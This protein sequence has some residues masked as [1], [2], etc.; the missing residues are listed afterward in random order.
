MSRLRSTKSLDRPVA[1][2]LPKK[3]I[4]IYCEGELTEP[5]YFTAMKQA[6]KN[7]MVEIVAGVGVPLT[8]ARKAAKEV[9]ARKRQP[10]AE[11]D[12]VWAVFDHDEHPKVSEAIDI[13]RRGAVCV[14]YSN[15]CFE[16]WLILHFKDYDSSVDRHKV[17]D[18]FAS[19][20]SGYDRAKSK[21]ANFENWIDKVTEAEERAERQAQNREAE[22]MPLGPPYTSVYK[23][24]RSIRQA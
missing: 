1:R 23:L 14:A 20:C 4:V 10:F 9:K 7:S 18:Y 3:T 16:L 11:K 5:D 13:C 17:Q 6:F 21:T 12:E 22:R 2:K 15:P 8:I 24:T 19:V